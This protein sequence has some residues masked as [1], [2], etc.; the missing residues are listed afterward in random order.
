MRENENRCEW[1][2]YGFDI[3]GSGG[4]IEYNEQS[5]QAVLTQLSAI[6]GSDCMKRKYVTWFEA[7]PP[8]SPAQN[9]L[10]DHK[11]SH[12]RNSPSDFEALQ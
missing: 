6:N 4:A 5:D 12:F 7:C 1:Y 2:R 11:E 10:S 8:Y 3:L 9:F